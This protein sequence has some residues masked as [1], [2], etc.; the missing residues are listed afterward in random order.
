MKFLAFSQTEL[1]SF[2]S[3]PAHGRAEA[4]ATSSLASAGAKYETRRRITKNKYEKKR[5]EYRAKQKGVNKKIAKLQSTDGVNFQKI[6]SALS[7]AWFF[8]YLI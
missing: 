2:L 3:L 6:L 4:R 5:K 1:G 7:S 8:L